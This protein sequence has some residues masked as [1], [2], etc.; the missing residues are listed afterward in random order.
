[1]ARAVCPASG[2]YA[3]TVAPPASS[4]S[5]M[6]PEVVALVVRRLQQG[7]HVLGKAAAPIPDA[8]KEERGTN[9]PIR[10]NR[11][12]H[13][14]HVR[15]DQLAHVRNLVHERD[16]GRQDGVR[17]VLAQLGAGRIHHHDWRAGSR[18]RRVQLPHHTRRSLIVAAD[19]DA[20]RLH[21]VF[22]RR[23]L[24]QELR[25]AHDAEG[26]R[27]LAGDGR[28]D[29]FG[30]PDRDRALVH[31]DGVFVDRAS[32]GPRDGED[33]L[34]IRR[35]VLALRCTHGD[36]HDLRC[37]NGGRQVRR[38]GQA[39][40]V[41]ATDDL[42]ESGLVDRHAARFERGD[43]RCILVHADDIVSVLRQTRTE[44]Q[45]DIPGSYDGDVHFTIRY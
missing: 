23:T 35:S 14:I 20:V 10:A 32:D 43:L 13:L 6:D 24:L 21:E 19:D 30:R 39:L 33:V 31:D 15:A 16:A 7:L 29:A 26:M 42:L 37:G 38:E 17:R 34:E 8:G 25:I 4:S 45:T 41:I 2:S 22:D 36:E 27:G 5:M 40:R 28:V 18:E 11:L 9:P 3:W 1:M 12:S 44:D